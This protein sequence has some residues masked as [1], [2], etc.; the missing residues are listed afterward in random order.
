MQPVAP[1]STA[2]LFAP[3]HA[4][5]LT[6]L[7]TFTDEDW[8]KPTVAPLWTVKDVVAHLLD[9]DLRRLSFQRDGM[10]PLEPETPLASY[11][12]LVTFLNQMNADWV[13]AAQR[14]SPRLLIDLLTLTG[15]QVA[16]YFQAL[17]PHAPALFPVAWAGDEE[18]PNW[19]DL[20]REYTEKWHHQQQVRDAVGAPGLTARKWLCP[21]LDTFM[22]GL[23]H[24]YHDL[25]APRGTCVTVFITGEAG[26]TWTL[27]K[28]P[29]VWQLYAGSTPDAAAVVRLN[30][31]TA[32][33]LFTKGLNPADARQRIL[34]E[35]DETLGARLLDLV[36]VMA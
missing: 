13:Q 11:G 17:D 2:D 6:L 32:W 4:E 21:V 31:D 9:G 7:H 18:S 19:F 10:P 12:D 35:G 20:A 25:D 1:V 30:Q 8:G 28:E 22:R 26:G 16:A 27:C 15:P 36:A 14:L 3:L 23:P 24:R 34:I 29:R 33:R 5:L